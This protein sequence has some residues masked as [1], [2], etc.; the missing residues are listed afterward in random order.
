MSE[1]GDSGGRFYTISVIAEMLGMHQQTL[2]LYEKRGLITPTR[3]AGNTRLYSPGDV[4]QIKRIQTLTMEFGVNIAGV[5]I[6]LEMRER[7][8]RVRR[9]QDNLERLLGLLIQQVWDMEREQGV[10]GLV[11]TFP[12]RLMRTPSHSRP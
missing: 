12:A 9:S 7:L 10:E 11:P 5:E 6:I 2:R 4:E 8:L 1:R 3:T